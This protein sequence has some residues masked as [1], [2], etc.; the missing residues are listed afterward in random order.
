MKS[1]K[2][3]CITVIALFAAFAMSA[4]LLSQEE[5]RSSTKTGTGTANPVPLI[6]Q[7]LVPDAVA[8]AGS[9]FTLTFNGTGFVSGAVVNWNGSARATAFVNSSQLTASILASD[10]ATASTASVSVVNPSPGGGASNVAFFEVTPPSSSIALGAPSAFGAG[11]NPYSVAVGDFNGDGKLDLVVTNANK[12]GVLLGNGDGT[13]R[14]AVYYGAGSSPTGIAVGDFNGDGKLDLVVAN[15]GSNSV[16]VR[17]GNGDGTFQSPMNYGTGSASQPLSVVVGDFNGD[18][19]LDLATANFN[20][21]SVSILLGNGDGTFGAAVAYNV[22]SSPRSVAVGDFNRDGNLDLAVANEFSSNVSVLL[23]NGDGTFQPAV[24]YSA[25]I[26]GPYSVAVGDFNGDGKLDLVVV[27]VGYSVSVLLG[28]GDGAFQNSVNYGIGGEG[29]WVVLGDFNGDGKLDLAV[30]N[31]SSNNVS[32]LLGNGDGTF[33]AHVEYLA[34]ETPNQIAAGDFTGSGR[35]DL[36]VADISTTTV[37][38]LLQIPTVSLSKTSL[39]F[40]G[41]VV[42]STSA[43]QKVKL[44]TGGVPLSITSIALT[45]T[46]RGDFSEKN[47]CGSILAP[48]KSCTISVAF[49]P[50]QVGPR[51]AAVTITDNAVDSPQSISLSGTGLVLGPNA[52]LS[53]VSLTFATQVVGTS[54]AAQAVTLSNYGTTTL[55]ITRIVASGDFSQSN[56]CGSSLAAGASCKISVTFDPTRSG[57]R[58]GTV[59]VTDNAPGSPQTVSLKGT[60]TVVELNPTSLNFG[61]VSVGQSKT[62]ATILTNVGST[63]LSITSITLTGSSEFSQT[64]TCDGSVGAGKSCT[65]SVT[66]KPTGAGAVSG[67]VSI[68]DNGGASPQQ[69]GLS[70]TGQAA[71]GGSCRRG[72]AAGCHC[73]QLSYCVSDAEA[74]LLNEL[75]FDSQP[76]ASAA[77]GGVSGSN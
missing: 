6:N 36:A 21:N 31:Y 37:S 3:I 64:N 29:S 77:C 14:P 19:K 35:L 17:L 74:D 16:S 52:T 66:F 15:A 13:F 8:P 24:Y 27:N 33:Q 71:C 30:A 11:P 73:F 75:F 9:G 10:I 49:A 45:G 22:G 44:T 72:C 60:G 70:G 69:V 65:I 18:G 57:T 1:A 26:N 38:V 4:V 54:S 32:V 40:A 23:G 56:T 67:N 28:D 46:N 47:N 12:V 50:T 43:N 2:L 53:P 20:A 68:S 34:G 76:E 41:Q 58:T 5:P 59:S 42:G 48:G 25:G 39:T 51:A 63:T 7:P 61:T 55:S 62:L